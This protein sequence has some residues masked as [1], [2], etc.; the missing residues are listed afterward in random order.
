MLIHCTKKL[1]DE[2]NIKPAAL[3]I[4][5]ED[6]NALFSWHANLIKINR[7]KTIVM[8]NN[9]NTYVIVIHGLKAKDFKNLNEII[10]QSIRTSLVD[11]CI[12]DEVKFLASSGKITYTKTKNKS[13]VARLNKACENVYFS[14][15]LLDNKSIIQSEISKKVSCYLV[16]AGKNSYMCPN[17]EMYKDL[18]DFTGASIFGCRA[19]ELKVTLELEQQNVWRDIV[20]PVNMTFDKL[21][22]VLQVVFAW[23][24]YHL[25]EFYIFGEE[26]C[27]NDFYINHPGYHKEGH[28]PIV[29]LVCN[30]EAF[31]YPN[32]VPMRFETGVKLL[33]YLPAKMKYNYDFGDN[34]QHYIE[35]IRV[36]DSYDKNYP[37]CLAGEGN[38]PPEDVGGEHGYEEF[39]QIIA[40]KEN[41]QYEF[42]SKWGESQGYNEFDIDM[43]NKFLKRM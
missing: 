39:L 16:G 27:N 35:V 38:T 19:V 9:K 26:K 24:D 32:D 1:L 22:K 41:P 13:L 12:K 31:A 42:M 11:E 2:L 34:W 40:D 28:R 36:I 43:V 18:E 4:A 7:K 30:E 25:H 20:V 37:V 15:D 5:L 23:Q 6:E 33:E 21:H 29:N 10:L 17:E 3:E 14:G 8:I